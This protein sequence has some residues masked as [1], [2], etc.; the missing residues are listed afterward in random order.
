MSERDEYDLRKSTDKIGELYPVIVSKTGEIVDGFHR[1]NSK[2]NWRREVREDIDTPEKVLLARLISNKFRRQV[3]AE[4]VR[5]WINDL[6]EIALTERGIEPG[7]ISGWVAEQTGYSEITV[8]K[9]LDKKYLS[10]QHSQAGKRGAEVTNSPTLMSTD[11]VLSVAEPLIRESEPTVDLDTANGLTKAAKA[12]EREAKRK[13]REQKTPEQLEAEKTEKQRKKQERL[14]AK[15]VKEEKLTDKIRKEITREVKQELKQE[16]KQDPIFK[17]EVVKEHR[18]EILADI[19]YTQTTQKTHSYRDKIERIFYQVR[20]WGV[21]TVLA[22]G[23]DEWAKT[24]PYIQGIHDW[25]AF[26]LQIKPNS[27]EQREPTLNLD[28]DKTRI[29]EPEY[30]VKEEN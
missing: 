17:A 5:G 2:A 9:Y 7:E 11:S 3:T 20:G 14:E 6:A 30:S 24:L 8:R 16:I 18:E 15:A 23:P 12:L 29:I 25:T 27:P 1:I 22:I 28:Y 26:L 10:Y 21:P 19:K 13:T 4:E